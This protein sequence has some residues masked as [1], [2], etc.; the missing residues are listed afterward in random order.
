MKRVLFNITIA[1][2]SIMAGALGCAP[3]IL[4]GRISSA[5]YQSHPTNATFLVLQSDRI[6]LTE[7]NIQTLIANEME[8]LGFKRAGDQATADLAVVYSY[9]IGAGTTSVS[10]SPDFSGEAKGLS[11]QPCILVTFMLP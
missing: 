3:S 5:N 6:T 11:L 8:K 9:S 10:S 7:R 1:I 4:L 2:V